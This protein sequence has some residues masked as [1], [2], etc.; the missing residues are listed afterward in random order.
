MSSLN[1]H[2]PLNHIKMFQVFTVQTVQ[3]VVLQTV[4]PYNIVGVYIS[5]EVIIPR[6]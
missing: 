4:T 6:T 2:K 3:T 1:T 5:N